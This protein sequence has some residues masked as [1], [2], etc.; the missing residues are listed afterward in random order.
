VDKAPFA[1]LRG[2]LATG[3][4][5]PLVRIA[6]SVERRIPASLLLI[7]AEVEVANMVYGTLERALGSRVCVWHEPALAPALNVLAACRF[8]LILLDFALGRAAPGSLLRAIKQRAPDTPLALLVPR[9]ETAL[10]IERGALGEAETRLAG[11]AALVPRGE[12][13]PLVQVV[14]EILAMP[15]RD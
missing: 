13:E 9:P 2:A 6:Y 8:R 1:T 14:R 11:A 4:V 10:A 5:P 3:A 15:V 7:A 12:P